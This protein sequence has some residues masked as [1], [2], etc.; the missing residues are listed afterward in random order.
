MK[1]RRREGGR[2]P[3]GDGKL[4]QD[5][6]EGIIKEGEMDNGKSD[7]REGEIISRGMK[8]MIMGKG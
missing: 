1:D 3:V 6:R 4:I 2:A 8:G 5:G 7:R